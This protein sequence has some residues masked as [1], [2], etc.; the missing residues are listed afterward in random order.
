MTL[1]LGAQPV[2]ADTSV[3]IDHLR[4]GNA[5]VA[6]LVETD[7]LVVHEF[8]IGELILGSVPRNHP[9]AEHLSAYPFLPTA[10]HAEVTELVR[11]HRLEGSPIGWVDAHLVAASL[12]GRAQ[13]LTR[14]RGLEKV[15]RKLG[16]HP[17]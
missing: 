8:V 5:D 4:H 10:T 9:M 2:L 3:W 7:A 13:L 16:L 15:A 1:R 6:L 12:L 11:V 17:G 14:D